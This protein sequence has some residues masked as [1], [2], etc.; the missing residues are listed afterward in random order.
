MLG[1]T[2]RLDDHVIHINLDISTYKMF[3][4]LIHEPLVCG[5]DILESKRHDL[6]IEIGISS[7][8]GSFF[9]T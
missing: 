7:D 9:F 3:E 8:E 2:V 5:P 1:R 6:V 4:N